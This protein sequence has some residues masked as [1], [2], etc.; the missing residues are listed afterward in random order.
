MKKGCGWGATLRILGRLALLSQSL[1]VKPAVWLPCVYGCVSC[2][3]ESVGGL[4]PSLRLCGAEVAET[5]TFCDYGPAWPDTEESA[6]M[7]K[8]CIN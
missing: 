7:H 5:G 3:C 8:E 6:I 2:P 1:S 4:H